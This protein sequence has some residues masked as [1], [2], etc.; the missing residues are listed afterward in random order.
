MF[1]MM[2]C[3]LGL[4]HIKIWKYGIWPCICTP[5]AGPAI[6]RAGTGRDWLSWVGVEGFENLVWCQVGDDWISPKMTYLF[7]EKDRITAE[8]SIV[9]HR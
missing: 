4:S 5:V 3:Q 8:W 1:Q 2:L 7:S 6:I 9:R